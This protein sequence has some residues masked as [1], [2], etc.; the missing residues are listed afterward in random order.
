MRKILLSLIAIT[1]ICTNV[2]GEVSYDLNTTTKTLTI[3]G[4]GAIEDFDNWDVSGSHKRPSN[5]TD[6]A[7]TVIIEEGV[8]TIGTSAFHA[9]TSLKHIYI[10]KSLTL[11]KE[12]CFQGCTVLA[13]VYYAGTPNEWAQITFTA[14]STYPYGHPFNASTESK[15]KFYFYGRETWAASIVLTY[16][17]TEVKAYAFYRA[18]D[19]TGI[20]IPSSVT[21]IRTRAFNVSS[22]N[23]AWVAINKEAAPSTVASDAFNTS[24]NLYIPNDATGYTVDPWSSFTNKYNVPIEGTMTAEMGAGIKWD[25]DVDG[26]LTLNAT[27]ANKKINLT[28]TNTYNSYPWRY[29]RRLV[30]KVVIKGEIDDLTESLRWCYGISEIDNQQTTIPSFSNETNKITYSAMFNQRDNIVLKIESASLADASVSNLGSDPWDNAKLDIQLSDNLVISDNAD[31]STILANC[32]TYVEKPITLQLGRTLIVDGDQY[33][34]FCSPIA[35]TKEQLNNADIRE[36]ESASL[37]GD[38]LTLN[39]SEESLDGVEAGKPYLVKPSS[40]L[41]NPTFTNI[42]PNSLASAPTPT[43]IPDVVDFI[44]VLAPT[45]LEGGNHNILFLGADNELLWPETTANIK[46]MRAYFEVK[47]GVAGA[48]KRARIVMNKEATTDIETV[49]DERLEVSG[50]K[51]LRNGQILIIRDGKEY[52]VMGIMMK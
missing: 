22:Y 39:F 25:L 38:E 10:P 18:T 42:A 16:G 6:N 46:G 1:T 24:T 30:E 19:V 4:T 5:W 26:T 21:T 11:C 33:N 32:S 43:E 23:S 47:G 8:T 35:L 3:S 31:Y 2:W 44:G 34:T 28:G 45:E 40:E 12:R 48:A 51:I 41:S 52:N 14:T 37:V 9:C 13:N 17:I 20:N 27:G 50:R 36:L 7:E 15:R 49:S 29:F